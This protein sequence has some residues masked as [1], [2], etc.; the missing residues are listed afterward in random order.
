[1]RGSQMRT[2]LRAGLAAAATT[3]AVGALAAPAANAGLLSLDPSSCGNEQLSHPFTPWLDSASYVLA[4][5]GAFEAGDQAWTLT[6]GAAA[7]DGNE[8]FSVHADGDS[9][10][11]ALPAG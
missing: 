4:P 3:L 9:R 5:G 7:Q 1:M 2:R 6:G 10:S 8:R 11:L